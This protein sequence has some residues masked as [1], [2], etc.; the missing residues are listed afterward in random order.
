MRRRLWWNI[1]LLY[2]R[3]SEDFGTGHDTWQC[4]DAELPLNINDEDIGPA[5]VKAP[6]SRPGFT[7]TTF[8]L[9]RCKRIQAQDNLAAY[10]EGCLKGVSAKNERMI[11]DY[12]EHCEATYT[13]HMT[14]PTGL[15]LICTT[16]ARL[17]AAKMWFN[18]YQY[19]RG[20]CGMDGLPQR[21][22]KKML[23][24]SISILQGSTLLYSEPSFK[25]WHWLFETYTNANLVVCVRLHHS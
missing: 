25:Q 12:E 5:S 7:D 11:V 13:K 1:R 2:N 6:V 21:E 4:S 24:E 17:G 23:Q 10:T 15:A 8:L 22:A 16:I 9:V 14:N 20:V 18:H 3:A 19:V